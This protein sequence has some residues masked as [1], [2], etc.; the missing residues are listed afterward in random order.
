MTGTTKA[1]E[2]NS[3][4]AQEGQKKTLTLTKKLELKKVP[5]TDQ[6]RQSFSHGRSKTVEVEVRKKRVTSAAG[7]KIAEKAPEK[8]VFVAPPVVEVE[9][10][11]EVITTSTGRRLTDDELGTR[12]KVVQEA[13]KL[14][15]IETED[16]AR[17]QLEEEKIQLEKMQQQRLEQEALELERKLKAENEPPAPAP[18]PVEEVSSIPVIDPNQIPLPEKPEAKVYHHHHSKPTVVI[19]DE[20]DE[21]SA[22]KRKANAAKVDSKRPIVPVRK[23]IEAPRK[24]NR[25]VISKA[26]NDDQMEKMRSMASMKRARQKL[27]QSGVQ[28]T[29]KIIRDVIIPDTIAVGELAN[30]MAVRGAD[31]VKFLMK[32]GTMVTI[33]QMIDADTAELICGEFGHNF[34]RISDTDIE[35]GLRGEEDAPALMITRAPV[36]TIMG[37]VDHGKTSL[38]D[39][40]RSTDVVSGEAGGITQHIGAYQVTIKSGR[41]ITFIDTPGHAAFS[42]MRARGANV[43]DIVV[44]VV[45]ADDGIMEQTIEAINHAKAANVPVVVAINKIDKPSANPDRVRS[46]LLQHNILLEE[47]GGDVMAVEVSAKNRI[48]LEKLEEIILLQADVLDLKANP[49]RA[50]E[51]VV[52]E[53][54]IDKGRGTVATVL[55]QRGTLKVGDIFVA[56]SEWGRVRALVNDHGQKINEATPSMPVEVLGF[57]GVPAAGNEFFVTESE[58]RAREVTE[59]RQRRTRDTKVASLARGSMEQMMSKIAAGESKELSVVIKADVQGSLEAIVSSLAKI[60]TDEVCARVLHGAVGGINESDITL[61]KASGGL[62]V[63]FNVRA[64]PQAREMA[65]RD[66]VDIRYYSIIYNVIDDAKA[67]MGGLLAPTVTEKFLGMANIREVFNITKVG[68][69]GGCF[70]T[71]GCVKRGAKVRLLR[72]NVVIHEGSLK[73]LKRFKDEVKEVKDNYECGMAFEN[74]TDIRAGDIIECFEV[75]TIARQL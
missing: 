10:P 38:L 30:R 41:K 2:T 29:V 13:L 33:N 7:E 40:L 66:G 69:V 68:K 21:S 56:G 11:K 72:D 6:V 52:V 39:A 16:R 31:V 15:A 43:T 36:V 20:D 44:L 34:K 49:H 8:A 18:L 53:A 55:I 58:S 19:D 59:F 54:E 35:L 74:Y 75:E 3:E 57:N 14:Q 22:I 28:E 32:L 71:E 67:I 48:G 65:R 73:T 62:I 24:L 26:L 4:E 63:G 37:H 23:V 46:E 42:E 47:Y 5:G 27:K 60:S 45:A 12:L 25:T 9:K 64:N 17:R 51:G 61:A 50:A 70:V 1:T